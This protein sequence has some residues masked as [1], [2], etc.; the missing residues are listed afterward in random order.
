MALVLTPPFLYEV[1]HRCELL[2][3][4]IWVST[5]LIDLVDGKDHWYA[6]CSSMVNGFLG[7][8]HDVVICRYNDDRNVGDLG[9][10]GTHGS[11][12]L[13]TWCVKEGNAL[14]IL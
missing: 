13:V 10:S 12:S 5:W 6:S 4:A 3:D 2:S 14:A 8:G 11:E 9:S 7:L 1:V